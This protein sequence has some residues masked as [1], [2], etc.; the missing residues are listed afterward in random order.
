MIKK[1]FPKKIYFWWK[2]RY[3]RK[4]KN[5]KPEQIFAD[6]YK[7]NVWGGEKGTFYSGTGTANPDTKIYIT[8][9]PGRKRSAGK[10]N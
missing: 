5:K 4:L 3:F 9:K 8:N 7:E 6:I 10:I 2:E 1:I